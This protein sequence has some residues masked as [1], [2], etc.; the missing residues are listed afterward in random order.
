MHIFVT[1]AIATYLC[2][3]NCAQDLWKTFFLEQQLSANASQ[4]ATGTS[5]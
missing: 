4:M 3:I 5:V 1:V 2:Y